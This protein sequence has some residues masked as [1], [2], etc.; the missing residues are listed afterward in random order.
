VLNPGDESR[1]GAKFESWV[2]HF[3]HVIQSRNVRTWGV[4]IALVLLLILI[5]AVFLQSHKSSQSFEMDDL[6]GLLD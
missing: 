2:M 1:V 3:A 4:V 6:Y 5:V